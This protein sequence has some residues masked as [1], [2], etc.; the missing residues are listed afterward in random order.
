[1]IRSETAICTTFQKVAHLRK[2]TIGD[3]IFYRNMGAYSRVSASHFNGFKAPKPY[4]IMDERSWEAVYGENDQKC[5]GG[6][7]SG[8]KGAVEN[9][10]CTA[11]ELKGRIDDAI[12]HQIVSLFE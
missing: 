4:Y 8:K 9:G 2:L 5:A 12:E 3:W 1:M 10:N 6:K 11:K 7:S